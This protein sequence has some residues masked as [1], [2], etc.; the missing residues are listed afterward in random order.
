M[1]KVLFLALVVVAASVMASATDCSFDNFTGS[2]IVPDGYCGIAWN[3]NFTY[4][5]TVQPP[6]TAHSAP[7]RVY[8]PNTGPGEYIFNF[9]NGPV[10]FDG[11]WFAGNSFA[12]VNFDLYLGGNLV[13]TS[14]TLDPSATPT[15]LASGYN[16]MVD[17]VGVFS[18]ANDFYVMDDVIY[19]GNQTTPE[20]ASLLLMGTGLI[21]AVGVVRRKLKA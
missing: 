6:Y 4:Y 8:T 21:G 2:G 20:P 17:A 9:Q 1:K 7:E 12:T 13:W 18:L 19:N 15:F 11:A 16:G 5:D 14:A 10:V 3:G